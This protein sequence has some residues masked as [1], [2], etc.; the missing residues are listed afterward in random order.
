MEI[1]EQR[2]E[3]SVAARLQAPI[4]VTDHRLHSV[5]KQHCREGCFVYSNLSYKYY[6]I[7]RS[8]FEDDLHNPASGR[9]P[10]RSVGTRSTDS[11]EQLG[12]IFSNKKYQPR[13]ILR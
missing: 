5:E 11:E 2:N 12:Q 1:T 8:P 7:V 13:F 10:Q 4:A 6:G 9:D 3:Q